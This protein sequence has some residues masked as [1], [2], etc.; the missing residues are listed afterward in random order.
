MSSVVLE[1]PR[2]ATHQWGWAYVLP[3][4]GEVA[5]AMG[6]LQEILPT[7]DVCQGY[8]AAIAEGLPATDV[9]YFA[10]R[11]VVAVV[12]PEWCGVPEDVTGWVDLARK[13]HPITLILS[14]A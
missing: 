2:Q 12:D 13:D 3:G 7:R 14:D 8:T 11:Q 6:S 1:D 10:G 5:G 4:A 9:W